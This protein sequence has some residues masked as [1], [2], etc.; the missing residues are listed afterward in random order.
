M[1]TNPETAGAMDLGD[2]KHPRRFPIKIK[3]LDINALQIAFV[4]NLVILENFWS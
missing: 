3:H 4:L 1:K 2:D